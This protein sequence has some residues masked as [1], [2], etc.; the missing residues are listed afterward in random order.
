MNSQKIFRSYSL[1]LAVLLSP[2]LISLSL[3]S[4]AQEGVLEEVLVIARKRVENLQDT[5]VAVTAFGAQDMR[6]AQI[7][8]L[9]DLSQQVPGLSNTDGA[10]FSG[11]TIRGV[12]ARV[13][14]AKVDPGVGVYVDGL[15]IPR[16]DTQ[17]VDVV[18]MESIQVLRGPQGTLFGK[19]TAGGAILLSS[20]KPGEEFEGHVSLKLG[21]FEQQDLSVRVGGPLVEGILYGALTYDMRQSDG[22]MEDYFTGIDYG[23]IDRKALVGQ[24]RYLPT[25]NLTIDFIALWGEQRERAAPRT[26]LQTNP[27]ATLQGLLAPGIDVSFGELCQLSEDIVKS[28][29]VVMDPG[30]MSFDVTNNLAGLTIDWSIGDLELKSITGY[31]HQEDFKR[32]SDQ[33]ATPYYSIGNFSAT[34]RHFNASGLGGDDEKRRFVSQEF[35]LFGSAFDEKLDYTL[36]IYGSDEIIEDSVGGNSLTPSGYLGVPVGENVLIVAPSQA[37]LRNPSLTELSGQSAAVFGQMIYYFSDMWQFTLGARYTWEEKTIDQDNYRATASGGA[38]THDEFD[39]LEGALQTLEIDPDLP[40]LKD[41]ESWS[42]VS[43]SATVTMFAPDSWTDGFIN[44]AMFYLTYSEGFKAGGFSDFGGQIIS[45][46]PETVKNYEFGLKMD[47][48]DQ[49]IRLN[50]AAY[51]MDY[52]DMQLGVTRTFGE[53]DAVFG[54]TTAGSSEVNGAELELVF[55][56]LD[57]LLLSMTASYIDA[58]FKDF[59]DEGEGQEPVDRSHEPFAYLPEQTYSWVLQYDWDTDLALITPRISGYYKDEV[60]IGQEPAAYAF[61]DSQATLDSYTVWNARLAFQSHQLEGFELVLFANNFTDEFYYGT[62]NLQSDLVGAASVVAGRPR[63]YGVEFFY[64]W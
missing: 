40:N 56:P 33:E 10:K 43:P 26:C 15:F 48:F 7:N 55:V 58:S 59:V 5:P 11:I 3:P 50:G 44:S 32:D 18:D 47:M 54:I 25:D 42:E 45:F 49:R 22:Y 21:D 30:A 2:V 29:K 35:N 52:D 17:L 31:L 24:L 16:G 36:G 41:E 8:N 12:G 63:N 51:S 61:V 19:N 60:Y 13:A 9:A 20:Q 34:A 4:Y 14:Q 57:G 46:E 39:Q 64:S 37:G 27:E 62:G 1:V 38:V 6:E 53:L 28:E 23:D